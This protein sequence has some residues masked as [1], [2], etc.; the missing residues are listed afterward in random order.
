M[1]ETGRVEGLLELDGGLRPIVPPDS[2]KSRSV[3]R[4][5]SD[6]VWIARFCA[7]PATV[8]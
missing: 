5:K 7:V 8:W 3:A 2:R 1:E 4:R 6:R